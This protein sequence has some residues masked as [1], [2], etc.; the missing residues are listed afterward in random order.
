VE[1][2]WKKWKYRSYVNTKILLFRLL[3]VSLCLTCAVG[4]TCQ[5][6][7]SAFGSTFRY[8]N[9]WNCNKKSWLCFY[10]WNILY[11]HTHTSIWRNAKYGLLSLLYSAGYH[12]EPVYCG[13]Q[14]ISIYLNVTQE[15]CLSHSVCHFWLLVILVL[16]VIFVRVGTNNFLECWS[17]ITVTYCVYCG[18]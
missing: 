14:R 16:L 7:F 13:M 4:S 12:K 18:A 1:L 2:V 3:L 5:A 11:T 15:D 8:Y 9:T 6:Q 17:S 10:V